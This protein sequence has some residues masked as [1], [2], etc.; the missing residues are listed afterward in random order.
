[1]FRTFKWTLACALG[2]GLLPVRQAFAFED[3]KVMPKGVR[4]LSLRTLTSNISEKTDSSGQRAE[5]AKPLEKDL[6]F[7]DVLKNEKD[8]VKKEL[9]LG[10]MGYEKFAESDAVGT[11]SADLKGRVTVVAPIFSYGLTEKVTLAAAMPIYDMAMSVGMGFNANANGQRFIDSLAGDYNNQTASARD[12]GEKI[13]NAVNR[14][15]DKLRDNGYRSI[16]SWRGRGAGDLQLLSKARLVDLPQVRGALTAGVVVPTG[17][18]DDPDNLIDKGFGDGQWDGILG[19]AVD[20]PIGTTGLTLNQYAKYTVQLPSQKMVRKVT[21]TETIEV[22]KERVRYKLGDKLEAG[23]S[24]QSETEIGLVSG[25]GYN[26][27]RKPSDVYRAGE[28]SA[29]LARNTAEQLHQA[30]I[31][32]GYSG[33]PAFRRKEI[34]VPFETRLNYKHQLASRNMPVTHFVQLDTSVFF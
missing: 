25:V 32:V 15:N 2:I 11:F 18:T 22:P 1:M 12:A 29:V 3:S 24:L 8:P 33:I 10:F 9:T 14:L 4:R 26:F 28:S 23:A 6:T 21:E 19:A 16:S 30:E 27:Y 13:N 7:R 34:P 17:R 20:E 5:L 31:E